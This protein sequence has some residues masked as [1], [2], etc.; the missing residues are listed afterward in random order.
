MLA[1]HAKF[2]LDYV[3]QTINL[4]FSVSLKFGGILMKLTRAFWTVLVVLITAFYLA[5]GTNASIAFD[6]Q[7]IVSKLSPSLNKYLSET[8]S[9]QTTYDVYLWFKD[10]DNSMVETQVSQKCNQTFD[11]IESQESKIDKLDASVFSY[12]DEDYQKSVADYLEKT[13][14]QRQLVQKSVEEYINSRRETYRELYNDYNTSIVQQLHISIQD[15]LFFSQYSPMIIA[16]LSAEQIT[17]LSSESIIE[18]IGFRP[19]IEPKPCIAYALSSIDA[20]Y[21]RYTLGFDGYGVKIGIYDAGRVGTHSEL[22]NTN[23]TRLDMSNTVS[24]HSTNVARIVAGSIGPAPY[25]TVYSNSGPIYEEQ[26]ENIIS[27]NVSVINMSLDFGRSNGDYYT[28]FEQWIDHIAYQ[29]SIT[30]VISAGNS[31]SSAIVASPGLAYNVI[32]VGAMDTKETTTKTDDYVACLDGTNTP[33]TSAGNGGQAGCS[34]PDFYAPT[35]VP[36]GGGTSYAAPMVTGVI[37]QMLEFK[38]TLATKPALVK[39]VLTASCTKKFIESMYSGLTAIEGSGVI[40]AKKAIWILDMNRYSTGSISTS[41]IS[42]TFS[43]VSSDA[44]ITTA[45]AWIRNNTA[46]GSHGNGTSQSA[47]PLNLNLKLVKPNGSTAG[48]SNITTSSVEMVHFDVSV[49]GTYTIKVARVDSGTN[50]AVYALAWR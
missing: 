24:T 14:V 5:A 7:I 3:V 9:E 50:S 21:V 35:V 28:D 38:P 30:M 23:I 48:Y 47:T 46:T 16:K 43:V 34:K 20:N 1:I 4:A 15:I 10:I 13:K 18:N 29:H 33:Y 49:Y 19:N 2:F 6:N 22:T 31:G 37:A 41:E 32:T 8:N 17:K 12:G 36:I 40:N 44:T 42:T 26:I 27:N 11:A 45:V 39:A 25:A